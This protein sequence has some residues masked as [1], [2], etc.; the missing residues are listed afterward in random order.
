MG[1][2]FD[3]HIHVEKGLDK[4]NLELGNANIIFNYV[5]SHKKYKDQYSRYY[6]SLILDY[7]NN[8]DYVKKQVD[9]R[10]VRALKIHNRLQQLDESCDA[11]LLE[12]LQKLE[13]NIPVIYDAFYFNSDLEYQPRMEALIKMAKALPDTNFIVAHSGGFRVLEYFF[14]LRDLPNIGYDLSFSLQY[15]HDSSCYADIKKL[16]KFTD[17]KKLFF[18]TDYPAADPALQL[19]ILNQIFD[20]TGLPEE[21]RNGITG[22]NWVAFTEY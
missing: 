22:D 4:Y 9:G 18:G 3:C 1:K 2:I 6:H 21:D 17:K 13:S 19:D 12:H 11:E 14:H 5:D 10:T 8:Y 20:E 15:L 7:Q 16:I